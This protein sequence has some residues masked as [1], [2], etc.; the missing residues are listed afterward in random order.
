MN[1]D[2]KWLDKALEELHQ[3]V[4]IGWIKND[5]K[6]HALPTHSNNDSC[7]TEAKEAILAHIEEE[8]RLARSEGYIAG[9]KECEQIALRAFEKTK[10]HFNPAE[11]QLEGGDDE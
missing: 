9:L 11:E 6:P 4:A 3:K 1:S 2:T 8:K 10:Q 5:G 7:V